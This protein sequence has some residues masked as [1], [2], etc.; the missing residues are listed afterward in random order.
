MRDGCP[1]FMIDG[2]GVQLKHTLICC[3]LPKENT[4][5]RLLIFCEGLN[6]FKGSLA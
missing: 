5:G 3:V 4:W 6:P 2:A 1:T